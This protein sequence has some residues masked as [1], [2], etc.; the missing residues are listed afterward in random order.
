V[1]ALN[2]ALFALAAAI[3]LLAATTSVRVVRYDDM[4]AVIETK[5]RVQHIV[6][7]DRAGNLE[8][9]SYCD[10]Q[11]GTYDQIVALG[12]ALAAAAKHDDRRGMA[13]LMQ[14]P[15]R[16]NVDII[17]GVKVQVYTFYVHDAR[18]LLAR[19]RAIFRRHVIS[20]LEQSEPEDVFCRNGMSSV[21]GLMWTTMDRKG[22]LKVAV[23][24]Q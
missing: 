22:T 10:W 14:Y 18:S 23:I 5:G 9:E 24:N 6:V 20:L 17:M 1:A 4:K 11:S 8:E 19:Y 7:P 16:I 2:R 21:G 15:L 12:R 13:A 3:P